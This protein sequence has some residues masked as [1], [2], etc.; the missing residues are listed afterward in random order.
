MPCGMMRPSTSL[1]GRCSP[2]TTGTGLLRWASKTGCAQQCCEQ[3]ERGQSPVLIEHHAERRAQRQAAIRGH[4]VVGDDRGRMLRPGVE[5]PQSVA[6][7][8][9]RLSP[10]PSARRLAMSAAKVSVGLKCRATAA[11]SSRPLSVQAAMP[12][13]TEILAPA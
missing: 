9:P 7:V 10:T 13:R 12:Q 11:S 6:P 1:K 5:M 8:E 3:T 2:G 4:A